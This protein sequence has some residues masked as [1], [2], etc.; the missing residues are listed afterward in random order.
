[1]KTWFMD[2]G[3]LSKLVETEFGKVK[4]YF[5]SKHISQSNT[6]N[7]VLS[8]LTYHPLRKFLGDIIKNVG[9]LYIDEKVRRISSSFTVSGKTFEI[10]HKFGCFNKYGIF[11]LASRNFRNSRFVNQ[12]TSFVLYGALKSIV[13]F[14]KISL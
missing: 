6:R 12:R 14:S 3:Y 5:K 7:R 1:M 8:G 2:R 10:N 4:F 9:V 13:D 11:L